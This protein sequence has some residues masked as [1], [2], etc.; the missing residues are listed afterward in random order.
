MDPF[1][2]AYNLLWECLESNRDWRTSVKIANRVSFTNS[3][4]KDPRK[5]AALTA[6]RPTVGIM[7]FGAKPQLGISSNTDIWVDTHRIILVT[8]TLNVKDELNPLKWEII[9]SFKSWVDKFKNLYLDELPTYNYVVDFKMPSYSQMPFNEV[10]N[11]TIVG[12]VA[13][14]NVE[15][16]MKLPSSV[17]SP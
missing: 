17:I 10:D 14:F 15:I 12:W 5:I 6:D 16:R 8:G 1:S 2:K 3:Y 9:R 11:L 13:Y 4:H 7:P